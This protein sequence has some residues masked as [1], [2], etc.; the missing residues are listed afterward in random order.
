M[1]LNLITLVI[2]TSQVV[3]IFVIAMVVLV[4]ILDVIVDPILSSVLQDPLQRDWC[5]IFSKCAS[6]LQ[7]TFFEY[8]RSG[9]PWLRI[10]TAAVK[11]RIV[12]ASV[13]GVTLGIGIS[14]ISFTSM[15]R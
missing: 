15:R 13:V 14:V 4:L 7:Q 8:L 1:K 2:K 9:E 5:G 12:K 3:F 11:V 10:D 6:K